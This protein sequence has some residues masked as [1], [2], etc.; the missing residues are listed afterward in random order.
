MSY[1]YPPGWAPPYHGA[2]PPMPPNLSVNQQQWQMGSWQFNPAYN[3]Q[4]HPVPQMQWM[5]APAW[6][7]PAHRPHQPNPSNFNPY[8]KVIKPPSAEYLAMKV[9]DNGLDLHNMV[10]LKNRYGDEDPSI[11]ATPWLWNPATLTN[12]PPPESAE[13]TATVAATATND[14]AQNRS[15]SEPQLPDTA[16]AL[17]TRPRHATDPSPSS[18]ASSASQVNVSATNVHNDSSPLKPTFSSKI[19]RTPA[20]YV[21]SSNAPSTSVDSIT[22]RM[23]H[24]STSEH[25]SLGRQSSMP[26]VYSDSK[27]SS[28]ISGV[29]LSDEPASILSP[30][31]I[32][33][34]PQIPAKRP[35]ARGATYP[36]ISSHSGLDTIREA[37]TIEV[38]VVTPHGSSS[39][40]REVPTQTYV[41]QTAPA[42][43][44][45]FTRPPASRSE[46]Y[47]RS[48]SS[49]VFRD[50]PPQDRS[51]FRNLNLQDSHRPSIVQ[52]HTPPDIDSYPALRQS[53]PRPQ[54]PRRPI[55]IYA[56]TPPPQRSH[57]SSN[58][59]TRHS[60]SHQSSPTQTSVAHTTPR[61][62]P[63]EPS[64]SPKHTPPSR[65]QE[66]P[67]TPVS[68]RRNSAPASQYTYEEERPKPIKPV[69]IYTPV[70]LPPPR[71]RRLGFWN[72]RGDH[73]TKEGYLVFAPPELANP[74]ELSTYPERDYQDDLGFRVAFDPKRPELPES[75]PRHGQPPEMPYKDVRNN[76]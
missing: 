75:L 37:P 72:R 17:V 29:Q 67:V 73:C 64:R 32:P 22:G 9:S 15:S 56:P 6:S 55:E 49:S 42:S 8:K 20:H 36:N 5:A 10:P 25:S 12:D 21:Q 24:L 33:I 43:Q 44:Q 26:S 14:P 74:A 19:V 45:S 16:S 63:P 68:L 3:W 47:P 34:T 38:T 48:T 18:S 51:V 1:R 76:L 57:S 70:S 60:S 31:I 23:E 62:S 58:V 65:S 35:I 71:S 69:R 40:A 11:P 2:A 41:P 66:Y 28:S 59:P 50:V 39:R 7:Y 30:L 54:T 27:Q 53:S 46:S 4:R 52:Q 13:R 61:H